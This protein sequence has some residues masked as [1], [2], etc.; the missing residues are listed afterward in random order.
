MTSL[1]AI[2][3]AGAGPAEDCLARPRVL[4]GAAGKPR[5]PERWPESPRTRPGDAVHLT[6]ASVNDKLGAACVGGCWAGL[7]VFLVVPKL[8]PGGAGGSQGSR[9]VA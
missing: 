5:A 3:W 1:V 7:E 6:S 9:T 8:D 2:L 4:S